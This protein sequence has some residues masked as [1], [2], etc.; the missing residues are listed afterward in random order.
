MIAYIYGMHTCMRGHSMPHLLG[1]YVGSAS[2][3][4]PKY[5]KHIS[6]A[7]MATLGADGTPLSK[8]C[9]HVKK[10]RPTGNQA[11]DEK[12]MGIHAKRIAIIDKMEKDPLFVGPIHDYMIGN[13]LIAI[14][15]A[16]DNLTDWNGKYTTLQRL[17]PWWML[18][19]LL[20]HAEAQKVSDVV[21]Q[22][23]LAELE[24][25][26]HD[27]VVLLMVWVLQVPPTQALPQECS[28]KDVCALTL[29]MRATEVGPRLISLVK[30]GGLMISA[31]INFGA[32]AYSF[33]WVD[34]NV[35]TITHTWSGKEV[36]V[37][38]HVVIN[39]H[40]QLHDNHLDHE[41][42]FV[43]GG[44]SHLMA[45]QFIGAPWKSL[46][47]NWKKKF[48][49]LT[50]HAKSAKKQLACTIVGSASAQTKSELQQVV[51]EAAKV[52]TAAGCAQ[53]RLKL[54]QREED[55]K[56]LRVAQASPSMANSP[57]TPPTSTPI[58]SIASGSGNGIDA[59]PIA[60]SFADD[61]H[62]PPRVPAWALAEEDQ[63]GTV[64]LRI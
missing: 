48:L 61:L 23:L 55:K 18:E 59:S 11:L 49:R 39:E 37:P 15:T 19:W 42:K 14:A 32:A 51:N 1:S 31:Q 43:C 46:L 16:T 63:S 44:T 17:P 3:F 20:K 2:L 10:P 13:D 5:L 27:K 58:S 22:A 7:T 52:R 36:T 6:L 21:N 35:H 4:C 41:A 62:T 40:F 60:D 34:G 29:T 33:K 47:V 56:R 24:S 12:N 53:A 25:S 54:K 9:T 64:H 50:D 45:D 28:D 26:S 8:L 57:A 30:A 38:S